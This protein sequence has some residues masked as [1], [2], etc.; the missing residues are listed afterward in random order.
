MPKRHVNGFLGSVRER[1]NLQAGGAAEATTI[2]IHDR[3]VR[4]VPVDW[5]ERQL[6]VRPGQLIT[7][8]VESFSSD[9]VPGAALLELRFTDAAGARLAV[10]GWGFVSDRV[11]EYHYL[12]P[13]EQSHPSLD[14]ID[15]KAPEQAE[16]LHIIARSWKSRVATW[17]LDDIIVNSDSEPRVSYSATGVALRQSVKHLDVV[18]DVTPGVNA[19]DITVRHVAG[20][21]DS[22]GPVSVEI[23]G[24]QGERLLPLGD[25]SQHPKF[26]PFFTLQGKIGVHQSTQVSVLLPPGTARLRLIGHDWGEKSAEILGD[27]QFEERQVLTT[28]PGAFLAEIPSGAPLVVIDTTAPPL[29]HQTL[30]LRPNNLAAAYERRG[31]WVVFFPFGSLQD[32]PARLGERLLQVARQDVDAFV[33][34]AVERTD[35]PNWFICSSFPGLQ[36]YTIA[37]LVKLRGWNVVY[38][39]RDDMEEFNRVGY[40]KW[41]SPALERSLLSIADKVMSVSKSLD[42]KLVA[43]RPGIGEHVV[44]PN[45]VNR[46]VIERG[47]HLRSREVADRRA[48]SNKV[49]YVGHLTPSWFD[50]AS[51]IETAQRLPNLVFEIVGHGKPDGLD[52]PHNVIYLG[53]KTHEELEDIVVDWRAGL[54]PF[55]DMPLTRSVDPNK[56]YE[57]FAWGLR[58]VTV[59]MGMVDEYPSTR[60]YRDAET[61]VEALQWATLGTMSD[62][63]LSV[64]EEFLATAD[65][66]YRAGQTL[67]YMGVDAGE[68]GEYDDA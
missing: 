56:I 20:R 23:M 17:V 11:G 27:V 41:Y 55:V 10:P 36:S 14:R 49:G 34:A 57:Y 45:A 21:K 22:S 38:E 29:G 50:W 54:I 8:V 64:L 2:E 24:D 65:W 47:A 31:V 19:V 1:V 26:G 13:A 33:H 9:D 52:L 28:D 5:V 63:E 6:Q 67:K 68:I 15:I 37:T 48:S 30:A 53:A 60:V 4:A 62:E 42:E 39:A 43:L 58:C 46:R 16:S 3:E 51:L 61:F 32:M 35:G 44:I 12:T 40:A 25:F 7:I 18:H 66:D 59:Q